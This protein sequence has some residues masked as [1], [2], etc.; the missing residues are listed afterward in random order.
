VGKNFITINAAGVSI[1]GTLINLN[2]GGSALEGKGAKVVPPSIPLVAALAGD[3]VAGKDTTRDA[4]PTHKENAEDEDET[5]KSFIEIELVDEDGKPVPGE[6]YR[7]ETP[8]GK[9]AEGTLDE[10]GF[11]RINRVKP[12]NCKV[13]F[14]KL[15]KDAWEKK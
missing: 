4:K 15:D 6:R 8:D 13:T 9:V 14:P 5:E 2:S 1:S 11:A 3:A 10:K 7:V 12:G